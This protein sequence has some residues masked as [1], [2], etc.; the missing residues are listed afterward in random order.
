MMMDVEGKDPDDF[1]AVVLDA[2][3]QF[4]EALSEEHR[5]GISTFAFPGP[6]L[7]PGAGAYAP[8][9]FLEMGLAEKMERDVQFL[10]IV[11]EV[12]LS[13]SSLA[14]TVA[15]PSQLTNVAVLSS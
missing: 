14:Y 10:L 7:S 12:D 3:K 4:A 2:V 15:L 11:T 9:D 6:H 13:S 1:A 5:L 8:L